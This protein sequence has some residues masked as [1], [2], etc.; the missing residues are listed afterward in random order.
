MTEKTLAADIEALKT[1]C[2]LYSF[3]EPY[4]F[5]RLLQRAAKAFP[6]IDQEISSVYD[7]STDAVV[8]WSSG[9]WIPDETIQKDIV[10]YIRHRIELTEQA[11]ETAA[12]QSLVIYSPTKP[13]K[14]IPDTVPFY[15]SWLIKAKR[16]VSYFFATLNTKNVSPKNLR[17]LISQVENEREV[18]FQVNL[19]K[20]L[21]RCNKAILK[22]VKS[23]S[24]SVLFRVGKKTVENMRIANSIQSY[25]ED[26]GICT[27]SVTYDYIS[28]DDGDVFLEINLHSL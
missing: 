6:I 27:A 1:L 3:E 20:K 7:V 4:A 16:L 25:L 21:A 13:V 28:L 15:T 12:Q 22:A 24:P 2:F 8:L 26:I 14:Y 9:S 17:N 5:S 11:F 10:N 18:V 19:N 23:N